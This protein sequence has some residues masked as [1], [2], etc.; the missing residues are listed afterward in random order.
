M[1][2]VAFSTIQWDVPVLSA[3]GSSMSR[4]VPRRPL[5]VVQL[6]RHSHSAP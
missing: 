4:G 1:E 6:T 5:L 3:I 2:A